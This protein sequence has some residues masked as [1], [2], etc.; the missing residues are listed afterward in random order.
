MERQSEL[1]DLEGNPKKICIRN[2]RN[3]GSLGVWVGDSPFEFLVPV[4]LCQIIVL[5]LISQGLSY[6]LKPLKTP[7]FICSILVS[8]TNFN[9]LISYLL[10]CA[11]F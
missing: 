1:Y 4:T 2:D 11:K 7:R 9:S 10:Y 8:F 5:V 3:M 6:V